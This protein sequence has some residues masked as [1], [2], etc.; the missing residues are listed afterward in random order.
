M[1]LDAAL[2]VTGVG[3]AMKLQQPRRQAQHGANLQQALQ[4]YG[5][6][7]ADWLDLSAA[8]SPFSWLEERA[9]AAVIS[10]AHHLPAGDDFLQQAM[11]AYYGRGGLVTAGSQ[12][13]IRQLPFCFDAG[14]VTVLQGTYGEHALSW[15]QAGH[16]LAE[17]SAGQIRELMAQ[18]NT[19]LPDM[20]L[21][22]NPGN[23]GG[24]QFTLAECL[25]WAERLRQ[26]QGWLLVDETFI[27]LTPELSLLTQP[28]QSNL[29]ILRSPGKFFGL[30]GLRCGFVFAP[31]AVLHTLASQ[32]GPWTV[33]GPAMQWVAQALTDTGWQQAQR[34]RL[35]QQAQKMAEFM[36]P[37]PLHAA[38]DLFFT[39]HSGQVAVW[40]EQLAQQRIWT[41]LFPQQRL[42]RLGIPGSEQ[43]LQRLG[44]ALRNLNIKRDHE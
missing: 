1:G 12:A 7:P 16:Q 15:Q 37:L 14:Q 38:T 34:Q 2:A 11:Q 6:Q 4:H 42:L 17:L 26:Q 10:S 5:G 33:T 23:P 19:R 29:I 35:Q 36:Q 32:L 39:L 20:L 41:R 9:A 8:I 25:H 40:H 43:A 3:L 27:D 13:A 44:Q 21:L 30:A 28:A 18:E 31:P 22:V 24:E